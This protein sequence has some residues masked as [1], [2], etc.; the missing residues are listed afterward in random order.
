MERNGQSGALT[1]FILL[2]LAGVLSFSIGRYSMTYTGQIASYTIGFGV[3]VALVSW[4]QIRLEEQE[5]L[6]QLEFEEVTRTGTSSSLFNT[7]ESEVFP[8]RRSRETFERYFVPIFTGVIALGQGAVTFFCW[9]WL[10][11]AALVPLR[12]PLLALGL[13]GGLFI[14]LFLIGQYSTGVARLG[15]HRLLR[16][17]GNLVLLAAYLSALTALVLGLVFGEFARADWVAARLLCVLLGVLAVEGLVSVVFDIYR[18]RVKGRAT[19]PLYD[20]RLVGLLS[21]PEGFFTTAA[22]ALD[23]QFGF[24]VSETWFYQFLRNNFPALVVAQILLLLLSTCVVF[25]NPGEQALLE[26]MGRPVPGREVLEPGLHFKWPYPLDDIHRYR[27]EEIQSFIVG[28]I[29]VADRKEE[30]AFLWSVNHFKEEYNLVSPSSVLASGVDVT[31]STNQP[32]SLMTVSIPVHY[33]ISDLKAYAYNFEDAGSVLQQIANREVVH[34]FGQTDIQS[35]LT[36]GQSTAAD[37]LQKAIQKKVD[38]LKLGVR[39]LFVG[40]QDIHPPV[41]VARDFEDVISATQWRETNRLDAL[42]YAA[43]TNRLAAAEANRIIAQET[44]RSS[45][46]LVYAQAR[47]SRFTNQ[48]AADSSSSSVYRQRLFL[49]AYT[50]ALSGS[51]KIIMTTSNAQVIQ[52]NLEEKVSREILTRL[53]PT[54]K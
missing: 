6:E 36:Q 37:V 2:L 21:H 33:Q 54:K 14:F 25:V 38:E 46:N 53:A 39:L 32:L 50:N 22:S 44:S 10:S 27:T 4:I 8:A 17:S 45:N 12:Q 24:K 30:V 52:Y 3:L 34:Y 26:R 28:G 40:L 23:Y 19:H 41:N 13:F 48:I 16:P 35:L 11:S 31:K 1:N 5:R 20:S 29:P 18:P 42:G 51:K 49:Q 47:A 15:G 43:K 7:G 9:R